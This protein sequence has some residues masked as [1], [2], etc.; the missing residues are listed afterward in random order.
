MSYDIPGIFVHVHNSAEPFQA[1][2][3]VVQNMHVIRSRLLKKLPHPTFICGKALNLSSK[4]I[5]KGRKMVPRCEE[6]HCSNSVSWPISAFSVLTCI[7]IC[8]YSLQ[9][10]FALF[11]KSDF[12]YFPHLTAGGGEEEEAGDGT[13]RGKWPTRLLWASKQKLN[14]RF[15]AR[16]R[17]SRSRCSLQRL[18]WSPSGHVGGGV[19]RFGVKIKKARFF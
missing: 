2:S 3:R 10:A 4:A 9:V 6:F 11:R 18:I 19:K 17:K 12:D 7:K 15:W 13:S 5:W 8:R 16:S 14:Y 1:T